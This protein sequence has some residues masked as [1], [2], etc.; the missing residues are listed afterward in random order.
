MLARSTSR[1]VVI[2]VLAGPASGQ[3]KTT[4][5][6]ALARRHRNDGLVVRTFKVGPDFLD[7]TVLERASGAPCHSL[8]RFMVGDVECLRLL[9]EAA[10]EADVILVEGV[11]GLFDGRDS[12]AE[13]A[14]RLGLP[15]TLV[16]DA[17]AMAGTF[18]AIVHG[19]ATFEPALRV[20]GVVANRVA[21]EGHARMLRESVRDPSLAFSSLP[22]RPELAWPERH[23]G[24]HLPHDVD[25]A[26]RLL[27]AWAEAIADQP[28]ARLPAPV[29]IAPSARR[30]LPRRLEGV[31]IG[32]ARDEAFAFVYPA[33]VD[34][35]RALGAEL[36]VF[37]PLADATLPDVDAVYLT[38]GYPEL[39]A[40]RLSENEGML[41]ALRRHVE[42]GK[43]LVAECGG[44][45]VLGDALVTSDGLCH[46]MAGL[47][48][49]VVRME[50]RPLAIGTYVADLP[51]GRL[52]GH[53]FHYSRF[54][55]DR[56]AAAWAEPRELGA[57]EA[58]HRK[59]R[60]LASYV[61]WYFPSNPEASARF[62]HPALA[63]SSDAVVRA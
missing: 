8:D 61:H 26:D 15:V 62:F 56:P 16:I 46:P 9:A 50:T 3:G 29:R 38:G 20:D 11:M 37:S 60:L 58:I 10:E 49:G 35:L 34:L 32:L 52:R 51:E 54:V 5:A 42:S 14:R 43:P 63:S 40:R 44:L 53:A 1:P 25:D 48:P 19:L 55:T 45:M 39:H 12:T 47:L 27:E 13:L 30:V 36:V 22:A 2:R 59:G 41:R 18:G 7:P 28:V 31:R 6:A 24:L 23:L 21:S 17:S 33:N 57:P 4:V